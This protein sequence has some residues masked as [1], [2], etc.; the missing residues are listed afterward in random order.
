MQRKVLWV[1]IVQGGSPALASSGV[2]THQAETIIFVFISS[3]VFVNLTN[4]L[5]AFC[6][7]LITSNDSISMLNAALCSPARSMTT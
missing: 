5:L 1:I 2:F 6:C 3:H 4:V 7:S